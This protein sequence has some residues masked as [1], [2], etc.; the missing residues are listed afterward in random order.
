M[1]AQ[2]AEMRAQ[3]ERLQRGQP[4]LPPAELT[5]L[6]RALARER[7]AHAQIEAHPALQ[8]LSRGLGQSIN[9]REQRLR[10]LHPSL[11]ERLQYAAG[12][13]ASL[14]S[15]SREWEAARLRAQLS[16]L[17]ELEELLESEPS[18]GLSLDWMIGEARLALREAEALLPWLQQVQ[19][20]AR[21]EQETERANEQRAGL[22][23]ELGLPELGPEARRAGRSVRLERL[24]AQR[25]VQAER[26]AQLV[27]QELKRLERLPAHPE[28]PELK[29]RARELRRALKAARPLHWL[30]EQPEKRLRELARREESWRARCRL[31]REKGSSPPSNYPLQLE[32]TAREHRLLSFFLS[33]LEEGAERLTP[34]YEQVL[35]LEGEASI[36]A[37]TL[38]LL[39]EDLEAESQL[40][41]ESPELQ[42]GLSRLRAQAEREQRVARRWGLA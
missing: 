29:S 32:Q 25:Y 5:R 10:A 37:S 20:H 34:L 4:A 2:A 1:R 33:L 22:L 21:Q 31:Y 19:A 11:S 27:S 8:E 14:Q 39:R 7:E 13:H 9:A 38:R 28:L 12:V 23:Q 17:Q 15:E 24:I 40:Q 36:L 35:H 6:M 18:L 16:E 30:S 26:A 3:A 42:R 41:R